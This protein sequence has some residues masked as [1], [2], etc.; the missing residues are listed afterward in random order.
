VKY[1]YAHLVRAVIHK[2]LWIGRVVHAL[3]VALFGL[4]H[5]LT[6]AVSRI[7]GRA[8]N[9][10]LYVPVINTSSSRSCAYWGQPCRLPPKRLA[11]ATDN[12]L[13]TIKT[14]SQ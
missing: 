9:K 1:E 5:A 10:Y 12:R 13:K 7:N 8:P 2:K 11:L 3:T 4:I 6:V 14:R